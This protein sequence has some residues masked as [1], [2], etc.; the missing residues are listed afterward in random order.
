MVMFAIV[1]SS[2]FA[3]MAFVPTA[4]PAFASFSAPMKLGEDV[5]TTARLAHIDFKESDIACRGQA[6]GAESEECLQL[7]ARDSGKGDRLVRKLANAEPMS[8]T[9]NV[10]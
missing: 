10:F 6:W 1:V 5:R 4:G 2:A 9:P 7:M 3:S 8:S